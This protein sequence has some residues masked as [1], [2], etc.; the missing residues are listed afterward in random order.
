[1]HARLAVVLCCVGTHAC[2]PEPAP[3]KPDPHRSNPGKQVPKE[4]AAYRGMISRL[5]PL[6]KKLGRVR[7][8][9]WLAS[10]KEDGQSFDEYARSNPIRPRG[11]RRVLYVQPIGDFD[12]VQTRL[13]EKTASFLALY[14]GVEVRTRKTL[15]LSIVPESARRTHPSWGVKQILS[16]WVLDELAKRL[17]EDALSMLA[18]TTSDLWPGRGW[19]FVFGQASLRQRVGV[20][21][22]ARKGDPHESPEAFRLCLLRTLKTAAHETGHMFSIQHCIAYECN[23][24]GSNSRRESDR[25]PIALCPECH[26]KVAWGCRLDAKERFA[27]LSAWAKREGFE[28]EALFWKRSGEALTRD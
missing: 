23:M 27:K 5:H 8:G 11:K 26:A 1:M 19:N 20:W 14:F 13:I 21:S 9:D 12:A 17:P 7:P 18:L 16:T 10:H 6:H 3:P 28:S 24:C 2:A 4:P 25:R 22:I 15:P